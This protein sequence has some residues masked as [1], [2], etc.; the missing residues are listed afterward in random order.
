MAKFVCIVITFVLY[1]LLWERE[2]MEFSEKLKQVRQKLD[3]SQEA[4][5]RELGVSFATINRCETNK[6]HPSYRTIKKF[7][8]FC[9]K[10][11]ISFGS[12]GGAN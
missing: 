4:L 11:N 5:A 9:I 6:F 3:L 7:D 1:F 12:N 8:D 2:L 10:H